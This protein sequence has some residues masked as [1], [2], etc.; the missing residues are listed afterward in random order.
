MDFIVRN[1]TITVPRA[2]DVVSVDGIVQIVQEIIDVPV[3]EVI[4]SKLPR[5]EAELHA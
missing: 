1:T 4:Q 2:V 5:S 3:L